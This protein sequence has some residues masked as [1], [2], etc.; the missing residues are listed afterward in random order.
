MLDA[1][2]V[3]DGPQAGIQF[4]ARPPSSPSA[5]HAATSPLMGPSGVGLG[6]PGASISTRPHPSTRAASPSH[7]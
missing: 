3:A 1:H 6:T 5:R 4:A 2:G 7:A